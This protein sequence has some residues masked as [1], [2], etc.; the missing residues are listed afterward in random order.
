V[1]GGARPDPDRSEADRSDDPRICDHVPLRR[2]FLFPWFLAAV[3]AF[4]G[5]LARNERM[6]SR[7]YPTTVKAR[8]SLVFVRPKTRKNC[9]GC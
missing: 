5:F 9:A 2:F 8:R 4:A 1:G 6:A 7:W 3:T